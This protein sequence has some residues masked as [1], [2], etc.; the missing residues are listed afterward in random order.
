MF[1]GA[2]GVEGKMEGLREIDLY[3]VGAYMVSGQSGDELI[4]MVKEAMAKG[5]LLVFLF[6]GVGGEHSLNVSR[7]DHRML[8]FFLKQNE[9]DIWVA[10][11]IEISQ[12]VRE[13]EKTAKPH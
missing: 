2:R 4:G 11:M 1:P 3:N 10:P 9:K 7:G 6:H 12:Y 8:L 5:A 13:S